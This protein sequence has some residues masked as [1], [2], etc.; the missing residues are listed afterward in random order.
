MVS[1]DRLTVGR[2]K[3][4]CRG[5]VCTEGGK[6]CHWHRTFSP[7]ISDFLGSYLQAVVAVANQ[8][9]LLEP[10]HPLT[11]LRLNQHH[12]GRDFLFCLVC[13]TQKGRSAAESHFHLFVTENRGAIRHQHLL[14][15]DLPF[16]QPD[17]LINNW[18]ACGLPL[19]M[20][21]E[22][23]GKWNNAS[24]SCTIKAWH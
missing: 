19:W 20:Q 14:A 8:E 4:A 11:P 3:Q 16:Y 10:Q 17:C 1:V 23:S 2:S 22:P 18:R 7:S 5:T 21:T 13:I 15:R 6:Q 9:V 12:I 24:N